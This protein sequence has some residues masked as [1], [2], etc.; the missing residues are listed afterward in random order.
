MDLKDLNT[1]R[2]CTAYTNLECYFTFPWH[3]DIDCTG[4]LRAWTGLRC[5]NQDVV[6]GYQY[7]LTWSVSWHFLGTKTL[8]VQVTWEPDLDWAAWIKMS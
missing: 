4:N 6:T 7:I 3:Q 1:C 2:D 8:T 5:L